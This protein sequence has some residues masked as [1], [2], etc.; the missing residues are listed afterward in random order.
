MANFYLK[1]VDLKKDLKKEV[2]FSGVSLEVQVKNWILITGTSGSG[3]TTL[4]R[5][6][7]GEAKSDFG[8]IEVKKHLRRLKIEHDFIQHKKTIEQ[9]LESLGH[10]LG[11]KGDNLKNRIIE[12]SEKFG[13][14]KYLKE[15]VGTLSDSIRQLGVLAQGFL[16][17]IDLLAFDE[18]L[19]FLTQKEIQAF[20]KEEQNFHEI[21]TAI[22]NVAANGRS[23]KKDATK[24]YELSHSNLKLVHDSDFTDLVRPHL[25][26]ERSEYAEEIPQFLLSN[27]WVVK[28]DAHQLE[29]IAKPEEVNEL[30]LELIK[31][32]YTIKYLREEII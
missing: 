14:Q 28:N 26:F 8:Y 15:N 29:L 13:F 4:L 7:F 20:L 2:L 31:R 6:L 11:M 21:G 18:P 16:A 30:T 32:G 12:L 27:V 22:I 17:P 24:I 25:I 1:A 19:I 3:K 5:M 10:K 23:F 9:N